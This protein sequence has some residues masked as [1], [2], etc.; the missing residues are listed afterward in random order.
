VF[1]DK[2]VDLDIAVLVPFDVEGQPAETEVVHLLGGE[3]LDEL[4]GCIE[5]GAEVLRI[6]LPW[7]LV[8]RVARAIGHQNDLHEVRVGLRLVVQGHA[9]SLVAGA[10]DELVRSDDEFRDRL[11]AALIGG[12]LQLLARPRGGLVGDCDGT[13]VLIVEGSPKKHDGVTDGFVSFEIGQSDPVGPD[14]SGA[15]KQRHADRE[16]CAG[17]H[18]NCLNRLAA[19]CCGTVDCSRR[20]IV[21]GRSSKRGRDCVQRSRRSISG[22]RSRGVSYR[23]HSETALRDGQQ[24]PNP[25]RLLARSAI[26]LQLYRLL[27]VERLRILC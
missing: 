25:G 2:L 11:E 23:P 6:V 7:R 8:L 16:R 18:R 13:R 17:A 1:T 24:P 3:A 14:G 26:D 4:H 10:E 12:T 9:Q 21:G 20:I 15:L 19:C 22:T 27:H 5:L